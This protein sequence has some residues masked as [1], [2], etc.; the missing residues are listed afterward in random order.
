MIVIPVFNPNSE[1]VKL[2]INLTKNY[3][4][5]ASNI[6][7]I[8]DHSNKKKIENIFENIKKIGCK[9]INNDNNK[10]KGASIKLAL[11]FAKQNNIKSITFADGD[12]QHTPKDIVS[13]YK[14]GNKNKKFII[15]ERNFNHAP[16]LNK[17][18]N[19]ISNYLFNN[20]TNLKLNDT[21][22]GLR[23]ISEQHYDI[24]LKITENKFDFELVSLFQLFK[25][26]YSI[27]T[28]KIQT[29]YFKY[30]YTSHFKKISDTLSIFKIFLKFKF[31]K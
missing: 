26:N 5:K 29:V 25:N 30:K 24:L 18:S 16:I 13:I 11:I 23:Y 8:N 4:I 19:Y 20:I 17:F 1:L 22:C 6:I 12:G 14:I 3:K 15:G 10:G 7:V 21:Q 9:I 27:Q 31:F 2:I 28:I